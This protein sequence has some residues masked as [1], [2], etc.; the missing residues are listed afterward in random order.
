LCGYKH[1]FILNEDDD[2]DDDDDDDGDDDD[3][4]DDDDALID[5]YNFRH[6]L[7]LGQI[8]TAKQRIIIQQ[9]GDWYTG[10]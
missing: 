2:D 8:K 9:Y 3:D 5:L 7:T 6:S 10:R 4:D 1:P